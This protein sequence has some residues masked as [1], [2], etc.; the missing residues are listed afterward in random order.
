MSTSIAKFEFDILN[1]FQKELHFT[2]D[3]RE[4]VT[5]IFYREFRKQTW[6]SQFTARLRPGGSENELTYT[7]NNTFHQLLYTYMRQQFPALRVKKA[8]RGEVQICW[9]HNLGT[10][11]VIQARLKFDDDIPQTIDNVWYDIVSQFYMRAGFRDHYNICVGNVPF[12][13]KWS[14]LLPEYTTTILQP[15]YHAADPSKAIPLFYFSSLSTITYNYTV[16]NKIEDLLRMRIKTGT[17]DVQCGETEDGKPVMKKEPVWKEYAVNFKY[18]EGA[19]STGALKTPEL[20]G[21]YAYLTED[22]I[23]WYKECDVQEMAEGDKKVLRF[24]DKIIYIED[25]I[26]CES[27]NPETYGSKV[28]VDLD[29]KTPSK[30]IFW[31]A[32]NLTARK[33][34]NFSNYS[35]CSDDVYKGWNPISKVSLAYAGAQRLEDMDSDHFDKMECIKHFPSPPAEPGYNGYSISHD[36]TSLDAEVGICMDGIKARLIPTLG[37]TDPFLKPVKVAEDEDKKRVSI[38]ELD[39]REENGKGDRFLIHVRL[40][41]MKKM[42]IRK[43]GDEKFEIKV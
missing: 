16:R 10:N 19:G 6:Y 22:E 17:I 13:E 23:K 34:R 4:E 26:A 24:K 5:S 35:T 18:I 42:V 38:D 30:A 25:I 32:E 29:C 41:V 9:P 14:D 1:E 12:L 7:V 3:S 43:I 15:F 39:T 28:S 40:L 20:W 37:N 21:R 31:V 11:Y 2:S 27:A 36:S 8:Y 33:N